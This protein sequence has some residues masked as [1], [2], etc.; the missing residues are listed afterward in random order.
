MVRTQALKEAQKRYMAKIKGTPQG[1]KIYEKVKK[2]NKEHFMKKYR[3]D[4][5]FRKSKN[6]YCKWR[7]YYLDFENGTFR[8]LRN[9]FGEYT[10][11]GR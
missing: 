8:A 4:E 11:Y 1:D 3:E 7:K 9:L 10:F 6:E 5:T 2:A